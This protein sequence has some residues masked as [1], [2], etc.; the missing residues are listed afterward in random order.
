MLLFLSVI[1]LFLTSMFSCPTC[2][3]REVCALGRLTAAGIKRKDI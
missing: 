3:Q 2:R 1:I